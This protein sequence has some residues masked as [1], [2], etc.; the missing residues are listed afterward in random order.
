M[1]GSGLRSAC[2]F[3]MQLIPSTH[4]RVPLDSRFRSDSAFLSGNHFPIAKPGLMFLR[5]A[6]TLTAKNFLLGERL[7]H[8]FS[9]FN[10]AYCGHVYTQDH[11]V[12]IPA[13]ARC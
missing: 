13:Q 4:Y 5:P 7:G 1:R 11:N 8:R 9:S 12:L 3:T 10:V 2:P 6:A